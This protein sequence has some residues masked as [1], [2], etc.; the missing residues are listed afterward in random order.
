MAE[1]PGPIADRSLEHLGASDTA[2]IKMRRLLIDGARNLERGVEP[3]TAQD[4]ALYRVRS[5][6]V[7]I[8]ED[9]DFDERPDIREGMRVAI[10]SN[11]ADPVLPAA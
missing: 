4:G 10:A 8:D 7:V 9:V 5:H 3:T 1:S 2:I 6:S 11:T